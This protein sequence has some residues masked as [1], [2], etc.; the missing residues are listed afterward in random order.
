MKRYS[1]PFRKAR[2]SRQNPSSQ[3]RLDLLLLRR[4]LAQKK[5]IKAAEAL[6]V[7]TDLEENRTAIAITEYSFHGDPRDSETIRRL[8][9]NHRIAKERSFAANQQL[10]AVRGPVWE[11]EVFGWI[12]Q[13]DPQDPVL[14]PVPAP[15]HRGPAPRLHPV[16]RPVLAIVRRAPRQRQHRSTASRPTATTAQA[17][18]GDSPGPSTGGSD[19][20]D[21]LRYVTIWQNNN[22][23]QARQGKAA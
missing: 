20:P 21:P 15:I 3:E 7:S 19:D 5:K 13:D 4:E 23:P 18:A 12:R 2:R 17:R 22:G 10:H 9:E 14:R 8:D 6:V 11:H 1:G 16:G